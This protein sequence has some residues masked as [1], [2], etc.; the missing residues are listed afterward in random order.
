MTHKILPCH[1]QI[2][3]FEVSFRK[4]VA[5]H[6]YEEQCLTGLRKKAQIL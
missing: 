2:F 4:Y 6:V 1:S 3:V 5:M